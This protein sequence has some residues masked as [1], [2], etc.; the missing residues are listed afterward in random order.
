MNESPPVANAAEELRKAL[1]ECARLRQS[2]VELEKDRDEYR[3]L[4]LRHMA[5]SMTDAEKQELERRAKD[6]LE[7]GGR[8]LSELLDLIDQFQ[9]A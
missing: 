5:E 2:V 9:T 3:K 1:E 6:V 7:N 4:L 8:P